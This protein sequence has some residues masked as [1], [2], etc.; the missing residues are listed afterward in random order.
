M[1]FTIIYSVVTFVDGSFQS[2]FK[3]R[4]DVF[5]SLLREKL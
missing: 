2:K 3:K 5:F 4:V 1:K